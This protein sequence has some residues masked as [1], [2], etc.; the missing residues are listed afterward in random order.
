MKWM[1]GFLLLLGFAGV[2]SAQDDAPINL[3]PNAASASVSVP[4]YQPIHSSERFNW[5]VGSTVGPASVSSSGSTQFRHRNG[6]QHS[7]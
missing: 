1:L 4:N 3:L 5:V 7:S 2:A 6:P